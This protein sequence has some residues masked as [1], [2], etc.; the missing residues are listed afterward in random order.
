[1]RY[2]NKAKGMEECWEL[3]EALSLWIRRLSCMRR[4]KE[5]SVL[6]RIEKSSKEALWPVL[7]MCSLIEE[8]LGGLTSC[9]SLLCL[10]ALCS[11]SKGYGC[12]AIVSSPAATICKCITKH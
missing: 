4:S 10:S 1:M 11:E 12:F 2:Q 5:L 6:E 7:H 9:P 8:G 3:S